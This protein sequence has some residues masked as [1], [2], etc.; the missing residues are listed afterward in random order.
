MAKMKNING[1]KSGEDMEQLKLSYLAGGNI[2]SNINLFSMR[3]S[4]NL[5]EKSSTYMTV[6]TNRMKTSLKTWL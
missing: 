2:N 5:N 4:F 1:K 6:S 3:V